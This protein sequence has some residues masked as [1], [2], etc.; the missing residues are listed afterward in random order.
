MAEC[1][2]NCQYQESIEKMRDD[3]AYIRGKVDTM[4]ESHEPRIQALET[5]MR[6]QNILTPLLGAIIAA[7][8]WFTRGGQ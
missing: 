3:V 6:A 7:W 1:Q 4:V 2:H 8:A 5:S